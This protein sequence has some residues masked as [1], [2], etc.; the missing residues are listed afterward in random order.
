MTKMKLLEVYILIAI[1]NNKSLSNDERIGT[2]VSG[3]DLKV[4]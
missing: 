2:K 3:I 1:I 4:G